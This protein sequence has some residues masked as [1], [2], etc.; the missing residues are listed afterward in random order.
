M[1]HVEYFRNKTIRLYATERITPTEHYWIIEGEKFTKSEL[2]A[3]Y[4]I[5]GVLQSWKEKENY[6]GENPDKRNL[7]LKS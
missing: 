2:D 1:T 5:H 7:W 3:K 4:P 6:K